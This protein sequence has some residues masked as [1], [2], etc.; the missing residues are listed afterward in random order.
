MALLIAGYAGFY[1]CR[2]N[3]SVATP[4]LLDEYGPLGVT[5]AWIGSL[6]SLGVL[7]YA[8]GKM[9]NGF[10]ADRLGGRR[11]FLFGMGGSVLC[12]LLF[13]VGG[14]PVLALAWTANR[15]VQSTGWPGVAKIASRWYDP[16]HFGSAMGW[17]SL[18]Y[19]FGD[20]LSR[21]LLGQLVEWGLG[22]RGVFWASGAM[23]AL[24]FAA[25]ALG[26]K[27]SPGDVGLPEPASGGADTPA[28]GSAVE[29]VSAR[30][31]L[32]PLLRS[33]IFYTV[34]ALAFGFSLIRETFNTWTPQYLTEVAHMAPGPAAKAS[35]CFP[36]LG[37]VSVVAWG[38][39][40]DR[41][42]PRW[43]PIMVLGSLLLVIPAL[44]SLAWS[45]AGGSPVPAMCVVG[46]VALVM[47]G[48][49]SY[50]AGAMGLEFGG[51]RA[52]ATACGCIDGF[53][54]LGGV[55]AGQGMAEIVVRCG[56]RQAFAVLAGAA[57][58]AAIGGGVYW[59]QTALSGTTRP[60]RRRRDGA[61]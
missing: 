11:V 58:V 33:P 31:V 13:G 22:W 43:R 12:T 28:R 7:F 20:F 26:L 25:C 10:V 32:V 6:A 55:L 53:G 24:L 17:I 5:K 40:S 21:V 59:A 29:R 51:R 3:L 54:S 41:L 15:L 19:L 38:V 52:A 61:G 47:M 16:A 46:L 36:L 42:G 34:C 2:V 35:S 44:L 4:L 18:S 9:L 23:L 57:V 39:A 37:G 1:L 30:E 8:L 48:P 49:Y 27:D 56:W 14:L 50:L 45:D 60:P